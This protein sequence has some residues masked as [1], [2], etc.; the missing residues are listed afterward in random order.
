MA[1]RE[2][3]PVPVPAPRPQDFAASVQPRVQIE[4]PKDQI[5]SFLKTS[6]SDDSRTVMAAQR[7]LARLG[8]GVKVDGMM[9]AST[10]QAIEK[11]EQSRK[12]P[13]T[14]DLSART[15]KELAAQSR[16]AAQ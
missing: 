16:I 5:G 9:G 13:V 1:A 7:A 8:Y 2:E 3:A 12:I 4:P 15:L 6:G 14:G 11:F 10:R